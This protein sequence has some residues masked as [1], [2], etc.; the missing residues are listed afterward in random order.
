VIGV[1]RQARSIREMQNGQSM[2]EVAVALPFLMLIVVALVEMGIVFASYLSLVNATREGA[3]FA[4][5]HPELVSTQC[6][7]TPYPTCTLNAAKDTAPFGSS[8][9]TSTTVWSEY[10]NRVSNEVFVV[11][12]EALERGQL[13]DQDVLLVYRPVADP[14]CSATL[15]PGCT[16]TVTVNYQ[17][18]TL[19]SGISLPGFGRMGLPNNYQINYSMVTPIR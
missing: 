5:M 9:T 13:L 18:H 12:G 2:V 17:I 4:S 11:L 6:G 7:S 3:I 15:G 8:G 14:S 16:I 1:D 10:N 19:T